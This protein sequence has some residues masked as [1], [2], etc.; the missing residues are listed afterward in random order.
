MRTA[1]ASLLQQLD[2]QRTE[3]GDEEN[4][5]NSVGGLPISPLPALGP[6]IPYQSYPPDPTAAAAAF[7]EGSEGSKGVIVGENEKVPLL[8][9][10]G[11]G[12]GGSS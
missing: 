2:F 6:G 3:E 11:G 4:E 8:G 5:G 1:E 9:G 12:G 10:G 7:A